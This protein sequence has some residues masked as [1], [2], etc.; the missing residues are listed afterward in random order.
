MAPKTKK[1]TSRK[2]GA[3]N[4]VVVES[5][6]KAR[7]IARILGKEYTIAASLGHVRDL[8]KGKLGIDIDHEFTPSYSV[9]R[10]KAA[11]VKEL[12]ELGKD[13]TSIYL[14]TDPDREGEAI[15]WH[16]VKALG[17]DRDS[18]NLHRVVFHE[19]TEKAIQEAFKHTRGL[20]QDLID[21]Q[22]ARRILDRLVG[23]QLSPLLWKKIQ[24]GLS[25]GRVQSVALR[26]VV[27]REREI[28]AFVSK[29]YWTLEAKL[30]K[31]S[32]SFTATLHSVKGER[33]KIE[34]PNQSRVQEIERD[35]KAATYLVG[36]VKTE[37]KR[38]RPSPPFTTS[39]LQQEAWRKLR[40]SARKTM[41]IAQQLYEGLALEGE[42]SVG[43]IT[44]MRTDSTS[45]ASSAVAEAREYIKERFGQEY[46]PKDPRAYRTKS[47]GAQ[48]AH[49]AIRSTSVRRTP[50]SLKGHLSQDQLRLYDLIWRRMLAC[51]MADAI[52]DSTSVDVET[53][54]NGSSPSYIFRATGTQ[55]KFLGFITLYLEGK[56]EGSEEEGGPLPP[57]AVG[58][59]LDCLGLEAKQHF[60]Q[61]PARYTEASLVKLMEEK[62]I[63]RPSTY[64]PTLSTLTDRSYVVKEQNRLKP[65]ALGAQ[66]SD[67]LTQFFPDIMDVDF[68]ANMED[69]LDEIARGERPW[70]PMLEAFYLPFKKTLDE[71]QA[72]MPRVKVEEPTDEICD[73]CRS[74]MVIK[75]GRFGRFLACST[76]PECRNTK[77]ILKRTG[78]ACPRCGGDL[79]ER[80][81]K[82]KGRTFYGCANYPTCDFS[83]VQKPLPEPCPE[84]D[85]LMVAKGRNQ[86]ACTVCAWRGEPSEQEAVASEA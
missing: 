19:I 55:S 16:L 30:A 22:Q 73:K 9:M 57:L 1:K 18:K 3:K 69:A 31:N 42:G 84:C 50:E 71:A 70:V 82:G 32:S 38:R 68:T 49:E 8:P 13:A 78:V 79:V 28:E 51:Q 14:A 7:T 81:S 27:D 65:T 35:L 15:S 2:N 37:E 25:A 11:I 76:F 80:R 26:Q 40:F 39:T 41:T 33:K 66:V 74:P 5:P 47:K 4:L 63:G 83:V 77:P 43:L 24:S 46:T 54:S 62:G 48:E 58:D 10:P 72:N 6:A 45:L 61:P 20:D 21:A 12:K 44:Y 59:A 67:M 52:Y 17:W 86:A 85:G 56:D 53:S 36:K 34:L 75:T 29:E 64:A 23:Y 60:T